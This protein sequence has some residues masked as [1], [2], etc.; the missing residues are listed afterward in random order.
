MVDAVTSYVMHLR[1]A[2]NNALSGADVCDKW[3]ISEFYYPVLQC[4]PN[5][6]TN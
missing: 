4:L 1:Y 3:C 5:L 2:D 6:A